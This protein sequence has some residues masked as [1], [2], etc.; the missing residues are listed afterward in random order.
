M[1]SRGFAAKISPLLLAREGGT[2]LAVGGLPRSG[3][4]FRWKEYLP[5]TGSSW[6]Q[7]GAFAAKPLIT[8]PPA[9]SYPPLACLAPS[10]SIH[11]HA[12]PW[13]RAA[14]KAQDGLLGNSPDSSAPQIPPL[15]GGSIPSAVGLA[16]FSKGA[17]FMWIESSVLRYLLLAAKPLLSQ[18]LAAS[19]PSFA[20]LQL[21]SLHVILSLIMQ[22]LREGPRQRR[23]MD[24]PQADQL[25]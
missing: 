21:S 15:R 12:G 8:W 2:A 25:S 17:R 24:A 5:S 16:P 11:K 9:T 13:R 18:L 4:D 3:Q 22:A 6:Q 7:K 10:D 14:P 1:R 19:Y 23:R 20:C